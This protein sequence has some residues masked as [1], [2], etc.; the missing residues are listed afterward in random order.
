M[1]LGGMADGTQDAALDPVVARAGLRWKR[2]SLVFVTL[3]AVVFIGLSCWQIIPVVFG[4]WIRPLP[5]ANPGSPER[6]CAEG[7]RR[8]ARA[9]DRAKSMAGGPSFDLA[10]RPD[11]NV[12]FATRQ[13]CAHSPEGL[14]AWAALV[15][16]RS[17]EEQLAGRGGDLLDPLQ[18]QVA[19]H[20]PADLR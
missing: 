2:I 11:W 5:Q 6:I 3:I 13:A 1:T 14:D 9:L 10:L 15:R 16:L 17:A 8:M 19:S 20:L 12:A 4:A 7:V 18:R